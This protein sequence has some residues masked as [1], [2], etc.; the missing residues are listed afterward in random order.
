MVANNSH[1][2]GEEIA[3]NHVGESTLAASFRER[4]TRKTRAQDIVWR[5]LGDVYLP[6][7]TGG[8]NS[9]VCEIEFC[10]LLIYFTREY[11]FM[12][13][14]LKRDVEAPQPCKEI[15]EIHK[16]LFALAHYIAELTRTCFQL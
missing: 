15:D 14:T 3:G 11:A 2:M 16:T 6:D 8:S 1:H 4:L 9:K 7:I 12:P 13:K 10:Q 5:N